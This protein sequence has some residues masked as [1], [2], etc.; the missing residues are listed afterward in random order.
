MKKL[1]F[2]ENM[3]TK[4]LHKEENGNRLYDHVLKYTGLFGGVQGITVLL[5]VIRNKFVAVL[6]GSVGLAL[7][8]IYNHAMNLLG[9]ATQF[10]IPL[11]AVRSLSELYGK[12]SNEKLAAHVSVIRSWSLLTAMIGMLACLSF[13]PIIS[14][15][16]FGNYSHVFHIAL[17]SPAVAM[18]AISGAEIAI[19]KAMRRLKTLA[20]AT[21]AGAVATLLVTVPFY[22]YWGNKGIIPSLVI[23]TLAVMLI[24]LNCTLRI[25]PWKAHPFS[26]NTLGKGIGMIRLGISYIL[27]GIVAAAAEMAVRSYIVNQGSLAD[28]GL[29]CAG[30]VLTVSYARFVFVSMDA[31]YFPRLSSI[32]R[33]KGKM[34]LAV[35]SQ[36]EVCVLLM[37][38]F[39]ILFVL[40]L[41]II[42]HLLFSEKFMPA[43]PMALYAAFYMFFKAITT[44]VAYI[45]LARG[46]S[47]LY[48]TMEFLYYI[49]FIILV[50]VGYRY[51]GLPGCG[52]A[53]SLSNLFDLLLIS[54]VY[55]V[56]YQFSFSTR[57]FLVSIIQAVLLAMAVAV[58]VA[59][60]APHKFFFGMPVLV[61]SLWISLRILCKETTVLHVI[62]DRLR[63]FVNRKT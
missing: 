40:F 10:G 15:L 57:P 23:S 37:A 7:I 49:V 20:L 38:P 21:L 62:K 50:I 39:L 3:K 12:D 17:L 35:N 24:Q 61:L 55:H 4:A 48:F 54:S 1:I 25:F 33:E 32:C 59:V 58:C 19:L 36:L 11:T 51:W 6:L 2:A 8:D 44:P 31:D 14:R 63:L 41:P 47:L 27:A 56:K 13:S 30:F 18:L 46:D 43:V 34:N 5:S 53:L 52:I 9:N 42:I 45:S 29:Y 16:S 60:P 26:R 28:E 22:Y